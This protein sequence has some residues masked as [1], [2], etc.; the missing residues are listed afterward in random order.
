MIDYWFPFVGHP[1]G[2]SDVAWFEVV[3]GH[4]FRTEGNPA[5]PTKEPCFD[6]VDDWAYPTVSLPGTAPT[7]HVV[8]SFVYAPQGS[9][10]FRITRAGR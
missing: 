8:G 5:G 1:D 9:A 10:W 2:E 4:G 3:D 6:V 7:F